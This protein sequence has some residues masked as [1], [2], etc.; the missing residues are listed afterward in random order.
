MNSYV[1]VQNAGFAT[2]N[3][4]YFP[5]P[6]SEIPASFTAACKHLEYDPTEGWLK[7]ARQ[8]GVVWFQH[9]SN[10]SFIFLNK[11]SRWWMNGPHGAG[12]YY[13]PMLMTNPQKVPTYGWSLALKD[14]GPLPDVEFL[15]QEEE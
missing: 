2:V 8:E 5:K 11:D 10:G 13:S 1:D 9:E 14:V 12:V 4:Q 7:L 6:T 15:L 3:G